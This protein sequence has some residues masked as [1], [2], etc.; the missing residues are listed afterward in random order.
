[1]NGNGNKQ[2][3]NVTRQGTLQDIPLVVLI[4]GGSASASEIVS[5]AIA[6]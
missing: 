6:R 2:T 5:G 4:N 3:L 1:M